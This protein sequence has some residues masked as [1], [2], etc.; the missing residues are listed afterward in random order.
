MCGEAVGFR[1]WK[2]ELFLL[3]SGCA[4]IYPHPS[5]PEFALDPLMPHFRERYPRL[6]LRESR[7]ADVDDV[8][9]FG[10]EAYML[11][12]TDFA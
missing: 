9:Q 7:W 8:R 4:W 5:K 11:K 3:C 10:W 12:P 6:D 2:N 1:R